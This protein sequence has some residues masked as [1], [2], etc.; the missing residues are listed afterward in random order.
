MAR[1]I[2]RS[3]LLRGTQSARTREVVAG[4]AVAPRRRRLSANGP[5]QPNRPSD[6]AE[7]RRRPLSRAGDPD[8]A[9]LQ[10]QSGA[11]SRTRLGARAGAPP[12]TKQTRTRKR[13]AAIGAVEPGREGVAGSRDNTSVSGPVTGGKAARE[14]SKVAS[15]RDGRYGR[16]RA[17]FIV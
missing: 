4:D 6:P 8:R 7:L 11:H 3:R 16:T 13:T 12:P 1:T 9:P 10:R 14:R 2:S 15:V 5:T 17:R